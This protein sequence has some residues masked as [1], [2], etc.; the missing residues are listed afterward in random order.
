MN[1]LVLD[2]LNAAERVL[3]TYASL[4]NDK[5]EQ[6]AGFLYNPESKR[7]SR[8]AK[9]TEATWAISS[10]PAQQYNY[11][12]GLT[13]ELPDL[14]LESYASGKT[15]NTILQSL[16]E[17]MVADPASGKYTPTLVT[18][19]WGKDKFG[20]AVLTN[21]N[22]EETS[23][24]D[25][26][27]ASARVSIT[28]LE[29]PKQSTSTTSTTPQPS[30]TSNNNLTDR[31][32]QDASTKAKEWLTANVS[33]LK[34]NISP[35][36]KSKSYSLLTSATGEVRILDKNKKEL[37]IVGTLVGTEF[38]TDKNTITK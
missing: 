38:K 16:Q 32:K 11:T 26:Q 29:V 20:P 7:Y 35:L 18:F 15:C 36:V 25:G 30:S 31:Q 27:V 6:V 23:W 13:L 10:L 9:Y 34:E 21:L 2:G 37:G 4:I 28:L 14:L 12:T 3:D 24:L 5:G 8:A 1:Q 19:I 33:K 17:L 22:W